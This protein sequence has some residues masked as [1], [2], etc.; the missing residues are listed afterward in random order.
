MEIDTLNLA[1]SVF[2][3]YV[4]YCAPI[5]IAWSFGYLAYTMAINAITG[6]EVRLKSE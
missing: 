4:K 5:T 3:E 1:L 2:L 6:K